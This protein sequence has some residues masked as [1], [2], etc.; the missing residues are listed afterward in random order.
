MYLCIFFIGFFA[1][2]LTGM[3][4]ASGFLPRGGTGLVPGLPGR[5]GMIVTSGFFIGFF[6]ITINLLSLRLWILLSGTLRLSNPM[7]VATY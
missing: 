2:D 5:T 1:P 4:V 3:I 7:L 6:I